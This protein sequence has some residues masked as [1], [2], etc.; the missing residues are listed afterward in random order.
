MAE[1]PPP[2]SDPREQL[3][4]EKLGAEIAKLR[5][6]TKNLRRSRFSYF[7][8]WVKI[9]G[10][11]I[12]GSVGTWTLFFQWQLAEARQ[13]NAELA[14]SVAKLERSEIEKDKD[15][16]TEQ[17]QVLERERDNLFAEGNAIR[18]DNE[19]FR[20]QLEEQK[21]TATNPAQI[22]Q[23]EQAA[24]KRTET[25]DASLKQISR[26]RVYV[27]YANANQS[28]RYSDDLN[29]VL[30]TSGFDLAEASVAARDG[31]AE[32]QTYVL[33]FHTV[34]EGAAKNL[35][36][37]LKTRLDVKNGKVLAVP[38]PSKAPVPTRGRRAGQLE[39]WLDRAERSP[40]S[41]LI[42]LIH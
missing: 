11:I 29:V 41:G 4:Q 1:P 18:S 7:A 31:R 19:S 36:T 2:N 8:D 23:I 40:V 30:S 26:P 14:I 42:K 21:K 22:T 3:E 34:D 5:V 32:D 16:L 33:Y 13:K 25:L 35:A 28:V 37:T 12:L 27:Y 39:V 24:T 15:R 6:E 38:E 10:G 20:K 9:A 17:K